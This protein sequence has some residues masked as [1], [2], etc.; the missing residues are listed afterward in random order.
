MAKKKRKLPPNIVK[1]KSGKYR[2]QIRRA[3]LHFTSVFDTLEA[4]KQSL[5]NT[6]GGDT[7][8][9]KGAAPTLE[10]AWPLYTE[11]MGFLKKKPN[12]Q[13]SER[14]HI[15]PV[16]AAMGKQPVTAITPDTVNQYILKRVKGKPAGT[17]DEAAQ[18][19]GG[20]TVSK[21]KKHAVAESLPSPDT[22]R[23]E[24]A[25]LS[26]VMRFCRDKQIIASNPT[27]G[28]HRPSVLPQLRRMT[29]GEEGALIKLLSHAKPRYRF[30]ARLC[31]LV[32]ETGARPGEWRGV[33]W[34]DIDFKERKVTFRNTKYKGL[35]RV[36]PLTQASI[37][38]LG[39]QYHDT[40][41]QC[42]GQYRGSPWVFPAIDEQGGFAPL[43]Y[44]GSIRD[45]KRQDLLPREFR[46]H[47]GRHEYITALVEESDL[48]D[49][50]IMSLV[51]HH[52]LASMEVYKHARNVRFRPQ[53]E[54]L[55]PNRR[56]KRAR[57]VADVVGLPKSIVD[58][59]LT[60]ERK[61]EKKKGYSDQGDERLFTAATLKDLSVF[62]RQLRMTP[63]QRKLEEI[64]GTKMRHAPGEKRSS[65]PA[66][67]APATNKRRKA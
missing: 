57:G 23:N 54:A 59:Y 67:R 50:R 46:P 32:R 22:V 40:F 19:I 39:N 36:I 65:T 21:R 15:K 9:G 13:A 4:A 24:V 47:N 3:R 29:A 26:A 7:G 49:S 56:E 64:F 16:L 1:L 34:D 12:T 37:A 20:K 44:S 62:A 33:Q 2:L 48:D 41:L 5:E 53:L 61:K 18:G 14:T 43:H 6:T 66:A 27:H 58:R 8:T 55:E 35:P 30:A 52:S 45:M 42:E 10:K 17:S 28:V 60:N 38:L 31:I 25:A 63:E 11:Q 51:G